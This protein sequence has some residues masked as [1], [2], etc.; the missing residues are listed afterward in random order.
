MSLT[1][2]LWWSVGVPRVSPSTAGPQCDA[3]H[4]KLAFHDSCPVSTPVGPPLIGRLLQMKGGGEDPG[5]EVMCLDVPFLILEEK[6]QSLDLAPPCS[7]SFSL[8]AFYM[9]SLPHVSAS[10]LL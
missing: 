10:S 8:N 7:A 2:G 6:G 1:L 3:V 5:N 4:T 9:G